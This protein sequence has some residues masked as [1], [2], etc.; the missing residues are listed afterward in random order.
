MYNMQQKQ[1]LPGLP[2]ANPQQYPSHNYPVAQNYQMGG[3]L[4]HRNSDNTQLMRR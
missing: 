3:S 1:G 4:A 2:Q